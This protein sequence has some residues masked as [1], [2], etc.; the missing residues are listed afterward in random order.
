MMM[1]MMTVMKLTAASSL[2]ER[3]QAHI[4]VIIKAERPTLFFSNS[5]HSKNWHSVF[6]LK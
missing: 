2:D 3:S 6:T 5:Y 4:S 1:M